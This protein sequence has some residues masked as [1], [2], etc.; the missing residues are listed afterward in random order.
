[1][2]QAVESVASFVGSPAAAGSFTSGGTISNV[3]A[4]AAARERAI[5][6]ARHRGMGGSQAAIYCSS[7]SHYSV[8]RAAELLGIGS[9][10]VRGLPIDA[11]RRLIADEVAAA[12][13]ADRAAGIVPVAV[14]A[15]AGT[16]LTGAVD[17]IGALAD[18]GEA[19]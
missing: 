2:R 12:I 13:D 11:D 17:P 19:K 7:E 5:P 15:T 1:E 16:T 9:E 18:V 3:T 4:L 14:V 6:E 10:G 8:T